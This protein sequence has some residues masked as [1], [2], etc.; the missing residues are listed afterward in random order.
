MNIAE[1]TFRIKPGQRGLD[2]EVP[3]IQDRQATGFHRA[4]IKL[5][6][7]SGEIRFNSQIHKWGYAENE[8]LPITYDENGNIY[9][10]F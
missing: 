1:G 9:R 4:E 5:R 2:V 3:R 8:V 7:A 6:S 10:G